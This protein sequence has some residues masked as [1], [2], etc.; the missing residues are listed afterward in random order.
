M[1]LET[2]LISHWNGLTKVINKEMQTETGIMTTCELY[3]FLEVW[4]CKRSVKYLKIR[5]AKCIE[6]TKI[7]KIEYLEVTI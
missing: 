2:L 3:A 1:K 6:E 4:E 5:D 7:R